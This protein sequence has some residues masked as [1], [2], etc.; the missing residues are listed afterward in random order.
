MKANSSDITECEI[1]DGCRFI[2]D[3][4]F[5]DCQ[6]L[7][8]VTVPESVEYVG[9]NAFH[10]CSRLTEIELSDAIKFIGGDAFTGVTNLKYTG[11]CGEE[12]E[13]WGAKVRNGVYDGGFVYSPEDT[14]KENLLRYIGSDTEVTI[15]SSVTTIGERSFYG[16]SGITKVKSI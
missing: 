8:S 3:Y 12:Y 9:Y 4:A 10:M 11:D 6:N 16:C 5:N 14:G 13:T 7:T 1:N 15:P 2:L